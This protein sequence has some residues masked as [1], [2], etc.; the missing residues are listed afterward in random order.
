VEDVTKDPRYLPLREDVRSELAVPLTIEDKIIGV[1]NVDST[2]VRAFGQTDLELLEALANQASRVIHNARLHA[3][4]KRKAMELES[5]FSVGQTIISSLEL[6]EVLDR[7]TKKA[8]E[9]ME[10]KLCSLML[11]DGRGE[12]LAIR[13][14][15]GASE[16]YIRKPN[17]KVSDSLLGKVVREK[18]PLTVEDVRVHPEF[19]YSQLAQEEGL[20][21][22]LSVPMTIQERVIG[23]LNVYTSRPHRFSKEEVELLTALASQSAIAIENARLYESV[24]AAEEKIRQSERLLILGEMAAEIAHEVRNPLTVIRMLIHSLHEDFDGSDP[25][26][27]DT[28]VI[29]QKISQ[30]ENMVEQ[31]LHITSQREAQLRPVDV[32][33]LMEETL[34][35]VRHRLDH[36]KIEVVR[37]Y[38]DGLPNVM[39]DPAQLERAFLNLVLNAAQAM[40]DGG[41]LKV[42]TGFQ[43]NDSGCCEVWIALEDTGVGIPPHLREEIFK[44]FF[45][46]RPNGL[47]LGLSI[48][49]RIIKHHKGH[50]EVE[51]DPGMG[52]RF[53]LHLP[54]EEGRD[55]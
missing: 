31:I 6:N 13:A 28:E 32:N 47:G 48:V 43:R 14:V 51:S 55:G 7:I 11:L 9:L 29:E 50:I 39:G 44:P 2:M 12:E 41:R 38:G 19:K 53:V 36:Q 35:L 40:P 17:L 21:S 20:V 24:V 49:N 45:S 15:H 18:R 54:C 23:L 1:L 34:T 42:A 16:S 25:R 4:V 37:E 27:R 30:M 26:K 3:Q 10:V 8:V 5:L 52:T 33:S 46:S 22:L